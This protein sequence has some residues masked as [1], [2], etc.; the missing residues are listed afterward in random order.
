M[1]MNL[2]TIVAGIAVVT[3]LSTSLASAQSAVINLHPPG[4]PYSAI[5]GLSASHQVGAVSVG[6]EAHA[7]LWSGTAATWV[8]LNPA[9][10]SNSAAAE[11]SDL[12]QVGYAQVN[13]IM[14]ASLW[15]GTA[16][17]WVDLHPAGYAR[18]I[19]ADTSGTQQVGF[20]AFS[21]GMAHASLWSGTADSWV[22]LNPAGST[23]SEARGIAGTQQVGWASVRGASHAS[24]WTGTADSWVSL[25]PPNVTEGFAHGTSGAQQV[26]V[27]S[28]GG[29]SHASLWH[30]TAASWVDLHP[31]GARSSVA[32]DTSG[33]HQ[34]GSVDFGGSTRASLW[35]GTANSCIDLSSFLAGSWRD[36]AAYD[37]WMDGATTYVAGS[38]FNNDTG[39]IEALLWILTLPSPPPVQWRVEDGGNGHWYQM[40]FSQVSWP[41]AKA[42]AESMGGHLVTFDRQAEARFVREIAPQV[43][44]IGLFQD[45]SAPDFA[46]PAGGWRWV[47]GEPLSYTNWRADTGGQASE[48][49]DAGGGANWAC[50]TVSSTTWNDVGQGPLDAFCVEWSADCNNDGIVDKGQ[51]L[52]GDLLDANNNGIPD[53][54]SI[55]AQPTDQAV[56][57]GNAATFIVQVAA[58]PSCITPVTY[59]WQRRNPAV[60]DPAAPG[61]WIDLADDATFS[62]AQARNLSITNPIPALATGYRCKI[63]GGCGCEP[64]PGGF[65]YTDTVNF[66]IACPADFNADGGVD[67]TDVEAFFE[68]WENGC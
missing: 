25:N 58:A 59:Q 18:S 67:F 2:H 7:S 57:V 47:T 4:A 19:A 23:Y 24:L 13:G 43:C 62:G 36:S 48:P 27:V 15:S 8:D 63:G 52:A 45:T 35:S 39:R 16:A 56:S 29:Q 37:I 26:G 10:A 6:G 21:N 68:R 38:A 41:A 55:A 12:Q 30:G 17:S 40:V 32:V 11:A 64:N 54:P 33:T 1:P 66:N 9:A 60:A 61:A 34:V 28:V 49:N 5:S 53:A 3:G 50:M 31:V 14:R 65:V 20:V 51:I 44:Q 22:N 42:A 46:E